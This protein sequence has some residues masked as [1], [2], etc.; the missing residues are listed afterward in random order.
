MRQG[1]V[2]SDETGSD[3][4]SW[5]RVRPGQMRQGQIGSDGPDRIRT[6][7]GSHHFFVSVS[8]LRNALD[9]FFIGH[10]SSGP[11]GEYRSSYRIPL[12]R[13]E[14]ASREL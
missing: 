14:D 3:R 11:S 1:K 13:D 10:N 12:R 9:A 6:A 7:F 2:R 4:V 8:G 5:V